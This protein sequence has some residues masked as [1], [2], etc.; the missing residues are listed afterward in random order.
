M[1]APGFSPHRRPR[2]IL[3]GALTPRPVAPSTPN[4]A[5]RGWGFS[6]RR[7]ERDGPGSPLSSDGFAAAR[8]RLEARGASRPSGGGS[9]EETQ[10]H[11]A[12]PCSPVSLN[13]S[14]KDASSGKAAGNSLPARPRHGAGAAAA[15]S[16]GRAPSRR[17]GIKSPPSADSGDT[18]TNRQWPPCRIPQFGQ[19]E[20]NQVFK[21][22]QALP[23]PPPARSSVSAGRVLSPH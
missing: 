5:G 13:S 8:E 21:H 3:R 10:K 6:R 1:G 14:K 12:S 9:R 19:P 7:A 16:R 2:F 23:Q 17:C 18:K 11:A 15:P 22:R 20:K 4:A